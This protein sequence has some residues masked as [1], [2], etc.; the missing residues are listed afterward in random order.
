MLDSPRFASAYL[1]EPP[2]GDAL[3]TPFRGGDLLVKMLEG[4]RARL[5]RTDELSSL[6]LAIVRSQYLGTLDGTPCISAEL[7][8]DAAEAPGHRFGGLRQAFAW[9]DPEEFH[10]ASAGFQIQHWDHH[11][12]FCPGCGGPVHLKATERAK[13]CDACERDLYPPVVP[14]IIV[15][16]TRGDALLM[17]RQPRFPPGMY[18]LVAGF[19]EPGESLEACVAREVLEETGIRVRNIQYFGSQPW[20]FPHQIMIGFTAEHASGDIVVDTKELEE[21]RW[22]ER[23]SMPLLPP[24]ISIARKL[25]DAWLGAGG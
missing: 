16:V 10:V 11:H 21:A 8:P 4:K 22:F 18:G 19:L 3:W 14:A 1:P 24:P 23:A 12:R 6:G 2:S 9:L 5:L 15:R 20:P 7:A 13:R 17:T 25:V